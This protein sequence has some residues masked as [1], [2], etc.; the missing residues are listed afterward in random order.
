MK[1]III[2]AIIILNV[3]YANKYDNKGGEVN[4]YNISKANEVLYINV[5]NKKIPLI[6]EYSNILPIGFIAIVFNGGGYIAH[7]K[8]SI[9][10]FSANLLE[11][12]TKKRGEID[13][14]KLLESNAIE[15]SVDSGMES[16]KFSIDFLKEKEDQAIDLL[17]E[18]I[19]DPNLTNEALEQTKLSLTS[20]LLSKNNDFDYIALKNLN[21]ILF[22]NT[23][24]ENSALKDIESINDI[25][26]KDV[27]QY[28]R[29]TF[30]LDNIVIIAGGDINLNNLEKKLEKILNNIPNGKK[31]NTK[32]IQPV[33]KP[34][35]II[36]KKNTKQAY[37]YFGAPLKFD[38][39]E[40]SLH[41]A[42][43]M[44][45][46]L[47]SSGFGSRIMEE[48]RVKRGLA[49]SAYFYN[50]INNVTSYSMGYL[51]TKLENK[52]EAIKVVK[53]TIK[54]FIK[55]GA[56][57]KELDDA[58]DYILGSRVLSKETISQ[59]VNQKYS[60]FNMGLSLNYDDILAE[61][62]KKLTLTE[63]NDYIKTHIEINNLFI[64]IVENK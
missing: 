35:K 3:M 48:V 59:R 13:F 15:L 17:G 8:P 43:I 21:K 49:Y 36:N 25:S 10:A 40:S 47:G 22:K 58:K 45:F 26:L 50:V 18:L 30:I 28:I 62:I 32:S 33:S 4:K 31:Y 39:Y 2:L 51:Q 16:L 56:T 29:D 20:Y 1:K 34:S 57:Q 52:D 61:K 6:F 7:D 11:R 63:L 44:S 54:D 64:S 38:N 46:I 55:N 27:E 23:K 5:K 42:K 14:A 37:I 24:L 9:A 41:K 12:G 60:N 19:N 53:Q